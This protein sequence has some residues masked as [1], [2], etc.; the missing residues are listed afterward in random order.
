MAISLAHLRAIDALARTGQFSRAAQD[1]GVSQPTISTQVSAFESLSSVRIFIRDGHV[2]RPAPGAQSILGKIRL[3]LASIDEIERAITDPEQVM[4]GRVSLGFSA[5]RL[6]MPIL[7]TFVARYPNMHINT[8]GGPSLE[9][10]EAVVK[11]ELD[12]AFISQAKPDPR[13]LNREL[14]RCRIVVYGPKGHSALQSG[15]IGIKDL[16]GQKLVLWNRL[17]ATRCLIET[18]ACNAGITLS[19]VMEVGTHDVA[20]AAAASGIGLSIAIEGELPED[21]AVDMAILADP[22]SDIGHY[23]VTLP[24]SGHHAAVNGFLDICEALESP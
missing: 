13:L 7:T 4:A 14:R 6:I 18:M 11:G 9:L 16:A 19:T 23:L 3:A 24:E 5:H 8:R 20:Y 10:A 12:L 1:L 21:S 17:S 22:L 15:Q 2:I